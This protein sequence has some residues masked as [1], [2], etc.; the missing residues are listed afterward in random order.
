V[1]RGWALLMDAHTIIA[2]DD[3]AVVLTALHRRRHIAVIGATGSGKTSLL[4]NIFAQDCARGDGVLYIDPLGDDAERAL[5][6]IPRERLNQVCY[7]NVA[8]REHPVAMNILEDVAPDDRERLADNVVSAMRGIWAD[9]G[10]GA[11]MEQILRHSLVALIETPGASLVL[12][13]RLLTDDA[14]RERITRRISNPLSRNFFQ[15]RFEKWRAEYREEAID[16]VLNK[17]ESFL[18]SPIVRNALGQSR[19]TLD[20]THEMARRH[21]VIAN[22]AKGVIGET[23]AHLLGA[24][25]IARVQA[26]GLARLHLPDEQRPDFHM[27]LD[28]AHD[29]GTGAIPSLLSQARHYGVSL[30]LATQ[31]LSALTEKT[32]A[33]LLANPATLV[34]FGV[35]SPDAKLLAPEFDRAQQAFSSHALVAQSRGQATVRIRGDD[36]HILDLPP[37]PSS[38][39]HEDLMRRQ[40]RRHYG[41]S[42]A[43]VEP[44]IAKLLGD[45]RHWQSKRRQ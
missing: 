3:D 15:N 12:L 39:G 29:F 16:P 35:A 20:F 17:I 28:E 44:M 32:Q 10:W 41:T 19:S 40:S 8:D 37:P 45:D 6:L 1:P 14:F 22:L 42:R 4:L 31:F 33:A 38:L 5:G 30:I 18:F 34:V 13:P 7:F 24:L 11:R 26:A 27:I 23:E 36:A 21:I 43:K 25:M 2:G 9:L